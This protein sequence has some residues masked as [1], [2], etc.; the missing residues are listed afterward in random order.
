MV[1]ACKLPP[2]PPH[3]CSG[4]E[5]IGGKGKDHRLRYEQFTGNGNEIR[6]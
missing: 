4:L 6:K 2:P 3:P 5:R 1:L